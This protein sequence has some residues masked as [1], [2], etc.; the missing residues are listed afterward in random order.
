MQG[1]QVGV[2]GV[3]VAIEAEV[4]SVLRSY[5]AAGQR[6]CPNKARKLH[7]LDLK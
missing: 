3:G 7:V 6:K 4:G 1:F 2:A 5:R